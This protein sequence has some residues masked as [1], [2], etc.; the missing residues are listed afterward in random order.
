MKNN[1]VKILGTFGLIIAIAL[2]LKGVFGVG[3]VTTKKFSKPS[4]SSSKNLAIKETI[5]FDKCWGPDDFANYEDGFRDSDFEKMLY[6]INLVSKEVTRTLVFKDTYLKKMK[7]WDGT[8]IPKV[9]LDNFYIKSS[10]DTY[11]ETKNF[12]EGGWIT[13]YLVFNL[14]SGQITVNTLKPRPDTTN[15][16]CD[17]FK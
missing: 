6:Q 7:D 10:T 3:K 17:K 9:T 12:N 15:W 14:K 1:L 16:Q 2:I 5:I 8:V 11:V 4:I 13:Y